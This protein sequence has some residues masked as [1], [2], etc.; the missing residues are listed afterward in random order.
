MSIW[1]LAKKAIGMLAI[2][3]IAPSLYFPD[4]R[5]PT[6][7]SRFPIPYSLLPTPRLYFPDS[8]LPIPDSLLPTPYSLLPTP[9]AL[10][11]LISEI[12]HFPLPH[13]EIRCYS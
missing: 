7:D 13:L 12:S 11:E 9:R 3:P 1:E 10:I 4:S 5:F 6:P 2:G 8:R